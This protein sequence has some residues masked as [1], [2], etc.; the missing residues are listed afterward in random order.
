MSE[1]TTTQNDVQLGKHGAAFAVAG[2]VLTG[3]SLVGLFQGDASRVASLQSYLFAVM[4]FMSL[5]LGCFSLTLL[6]HVLQGKWGLPI[7][8]IFEA[9]G[10]VRNIVLMAV[11][12]S[13]IL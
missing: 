12:F 8:R 2:L 5:T 13:P 7:L 9:G 6:Q 3:V 11:L 4:L 10:G 1:A